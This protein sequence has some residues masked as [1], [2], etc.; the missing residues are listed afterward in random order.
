LLKLSTRIVVIYN[1]E[2]VARFDDTAELTPEELG[3]YMLGV[4]RKEAVR[5]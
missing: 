2:I 4:E 1:G 3:P 5:G